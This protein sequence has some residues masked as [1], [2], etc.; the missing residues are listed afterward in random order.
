MF[1]IIAKVFLYLGIAIV[2]PTVVAILFDVSFYLWR[3][4]SEAVTPRKAIKTQ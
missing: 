3:N 4:I 1:D 2:T